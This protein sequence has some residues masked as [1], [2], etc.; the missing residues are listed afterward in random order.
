MGLFQPVACRE[1]AEDSWFAFELVDGEIVPTVNVCD[2]IDLDA[3][4]RAAD[5]P[6]RSPI[7]YVQG[8]VDPATVH[9]NA[10]RHF[11]T[12]TKADRTF[13]ALPDIGHAPLSWALTTACG[14]TV[15]NALLDDGDLDTAVASC[16][17]GAEVER[18]PAE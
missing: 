8:T 1:I 13:V 11:E 2:E 7:V 9:S 15:W 18:R 5:W 14:D 12:Q 17:L 16:D 6:I 3:P 10:R 4:Y